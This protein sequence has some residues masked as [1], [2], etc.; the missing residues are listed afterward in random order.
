[1]KKICWKFNKVS[2]KCQKKSMKSLKNL[3]NIFFPSIC[4]GCGSVLLTNEQTI[5][6]RCRHELP[7]TQHLN[8]TENETYQK[9]YGRIPLEHA[10]S[11]VYYHKKGITQKLIH[12]L[13]YKGAEDIGVF[14]GSIYGAQITSDPILSTVDEVVPVP[15][16]PK[17]QRERG[18]NQ[19]ST[20]GKT[21]AESIGVDFNEKRLIR[22]TYSNTQTT[23]NIFGRTELKSSVFD[24]RFTNEDSNKHFLLVDDVIT[25]G[26]T[27]EACAKILLKIPNAKISIITIAYSH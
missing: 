9:F 11:I 17:K 19:I 2:V 20:F 7:F 23:K 13:K 3:L 27:L 4:N 5:C 22:N 25:T 14:F 6:V 15:L 18:Y 8:M 12:N 1:M 10:S 24:V 26:S 16:H 21:I